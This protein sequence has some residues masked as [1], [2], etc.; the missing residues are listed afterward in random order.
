MAQKASRHYIAVEALCVVMALVFAL[1][2]CYDNSP[3]FL[4]YGTDNPIF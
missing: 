2:L 4:D 1:L 3:L